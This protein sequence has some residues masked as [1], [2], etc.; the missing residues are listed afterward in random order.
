MDYVIGMLKARLTVLNTDRA[1]YAEA[2]AHHVRQKE[3][4]V[5]RLNAVDAE[6][7]QTEAAITRL[8]G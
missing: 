1:T 4:A 6:I 8:G 7:E 5:T 2:V 3:A